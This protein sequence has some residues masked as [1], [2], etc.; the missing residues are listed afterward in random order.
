[1]LKLKTETF[2]SQ[3][4]NPSNVDFVMNEDLG[5]QVAKRKLSVKDCRVAIGLPADPI[6]EI[7]QKNTDLQLCIA[8][9]DLREVGWET[10][11]DGSTTSYSTF[12]IA[13]Q[14]KGLSID[15]CRSIIIQDYVSKDWVKFMPG[16]YHRL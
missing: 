8:A 10:R 11:I 2:C 15:D 4:L 5:A 1:M 7:I 14:R 12:S 16:S 3:A 6:D 13:A 9:L